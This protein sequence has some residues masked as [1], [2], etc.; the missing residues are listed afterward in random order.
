MIAKTTPLATPS[1]VEKLTALHHK[2]TGLYLAYCDLMPARWEEDTLAARMKF[3]ENPS[4][5]ALANLHARFCAEPAQYRAAITTD[6]V[7][8]AQSIFERE[9]K[10]IL[11]EILNRGAQS[12]AEDIQK[13]KAQEEDWRRA[14]EGLFT[15][16]IKP[17]AA[18]LHAEQKAAKIAKTLKNHFE[19]PGSTSAFPVTI[20]DILSLVGLQ[21]SS[22]NAACAAGVG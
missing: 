14:G 2:I 9:A 19:K 20:P 13:L 22:D 3:R 12:L 4:L 1:E 18:R 7:I 21:L 6:I 16:E 15:G 5:G 11:I 17:S 8:G 10:P